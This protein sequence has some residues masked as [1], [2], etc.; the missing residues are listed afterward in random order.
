MEKEPVGS[1]GE[2]FSNLDLASTSES[3]YEAKTTKSEGVLDHDKSADK[4]QGKK[5]SKKKENIRELE[6]INMELLVRVR[7]LE[8]Q[9]ME[10]E[11]PGGE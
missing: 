6:R 1:Q 4:K 5:G 8:L 7:E 9:Q 11:G 2:D 10:G 3:M